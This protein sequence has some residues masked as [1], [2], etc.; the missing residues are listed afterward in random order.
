MKTFWQI[1]C[2]L[3]LLCQHACAGSISI[4]LDTNLVVKRSGDTKHFDRKILSQIDALISNVQSKDTS[5][6]LNA[7]QDLHQLIGTKVSSLY[8]KRFLEENPF[9]TG[10]KALDIVKYEQAS[11]NKM[12]IEMLGQE[13]LAGLRNAVRSHLK[14]EDEDSRLAVK[15]IHL[16]AF[17]LSDPQLKPLLNP[18]LSASDRK[19]AYEAMLALGTLGDEDAF[20]FFK[21][22]LASYPSVDVLRAAEILVRFEE[23]FERDIV[24]EIST[25]QGWLGAKALRVLAMQPAERDIQLFLKILLTDDDEKKVEESIKALELNLNKLSDNDKE[26]VL[27]RASE[28]VKE[29]SIGIKEALIELLDNYEE[30]AAVRLIVTLLADSS[31]EV[32]RSA[33]ISLGIMLNESSLGL[34]IPFLDSENKDLRLSAARTIER[35]RHH[36]R[37]A[38]AKLITPMPYVLEEV[39][40]EQKKWWEKNRDNPRYAK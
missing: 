24:R 33:I 2:L 21:S 15:A 8:L 25:E 23:P 17:C 1:L 12:L 7:M 29:A 39:I 27:D 34:I 6:A 20:S 3:L 5:V 40:R 30:P 32:Q 18:L 10:E 22:N 4:T 14:N 19:V 38:A 28:L 31:T 13:R 11:L 16:L 26:T 36:D 37:K 9:G 35:I